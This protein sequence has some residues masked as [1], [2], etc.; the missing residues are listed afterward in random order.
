MFKDIDYAQKAC[1]PG[2]GYTKAITANPGL[3]F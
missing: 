3:N 2:P 1:W